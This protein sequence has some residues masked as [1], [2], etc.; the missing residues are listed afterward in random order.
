MLPCPYLTTRRSVGEE[1]WQEEASGGDPL[2]RVSLSPSL[3]TYVSMLSIPFLAM[4]WC[5]RSPPPPIGAK[6]GQ[7][8][9]SWGDLLHRMPSSLS[10][11]PSPSNRHRRS[12]PLQQVRWTTSC[13]TFRWWYRLLRARRPW[14]L[15]ILP[16]FTSGWRWERNRG[17][18][19]PR[20]VKGELQETPHVEA[21]SYILFYLSL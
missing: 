13:R 18:R 11:S 16:S 8:E 15:L 3:C 17:R 9:G 2:Q 5:H 1:V 14:N 21:L 6:V 19:A 10:P 4:R 7:E 12:P 20:D